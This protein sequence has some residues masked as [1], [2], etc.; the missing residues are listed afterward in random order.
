MSGQQGSLTKRRCPQST[1]HLFPFSATMTLISMH[2]LTVS[3]KKNIL[4]ELQRREHEGGNI[5]KA[6]F[7]HLAKQEFSLNGVPRKAAMSG[8]FSSAA[9]IL[10]ITDKLV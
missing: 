8:I 7:A 9:A 4:Q 6:S 3:L 10:P 2:V 1:A 5:T